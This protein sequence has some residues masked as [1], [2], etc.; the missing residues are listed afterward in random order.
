M[1]SAEIPVDTSGAVPPPS[2]ATAKV[3]PSLT[4]EERAKISRMQGDLMWLVREGYVTEFIDG[5]LFA[6]PPTVEARKKEVETEEHDPEN[7]PDIPPA[8]ETAETKPA[9]VDRVE[10]PVEPVADAG[11]APA[12]PDV[13]GVAPGSVVPVA[14]ETKPAS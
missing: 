2:A 10:T 5:R 6:P 4:V 7:F 11:P 8:S 3:E 14:D 9:P 12:T 1:P 13:S